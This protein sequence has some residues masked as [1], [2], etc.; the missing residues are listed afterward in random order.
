MEGSIFC[1]FLLYSLDLTKEVYLCL[2]YSES[3]ML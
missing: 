2:K 1:G 3:V